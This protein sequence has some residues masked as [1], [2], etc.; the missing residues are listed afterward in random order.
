MFNPDQHGTGCDGIVGSN[1]ITRAEPTENPA[2]ARAKQDQEYSLNTGASNV[3]PEGTGTVDAAELAESASAIAR[4]ESE[5]TRIRILLVEDHAILREGLRALLELEPDFK[6]VGEAADVDGGLA[7]IERLK[8]QL[9][10][11]A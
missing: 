7:E 10:I 8:P 2:R 5:E 4:S 3:T 11:P 9:V 1:G 6:V